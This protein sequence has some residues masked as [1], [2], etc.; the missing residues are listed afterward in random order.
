L[1]SAAANEDYDLRFTAFVLCKLV[2]EFEDANA[3]VSEMRSIFMA[4]YRPLSQQTQVWITA[5]GTLQ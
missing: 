2:I 3:A 5:E 4:L 1:H